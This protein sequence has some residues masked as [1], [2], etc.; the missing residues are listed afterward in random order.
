MSLLEDDIRLNQPRAFACSTGASQAFNASRAHY[1]APKYE[2][3][4]HF[5]EVD[6]QATVPHLYYLYNKMGSRPHY[7]PSQKVR[8]VRARVTGSYVPS[9]A[10]SICPTR[11]SCTLVRR[12]PFFAAPFGQSVDFAAAIT[13]FYYQTCYSTV[14]GAP[15]WDR[16]HDRELVFL[17]EGTLARVRRQ[18]G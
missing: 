12:A 8:Q 2:G 13:T 11:A 15:H 3:I 10:C 5:H 6:A 7:L 17:A 18:W 4:F 9:L 1:T 16:A 14:S